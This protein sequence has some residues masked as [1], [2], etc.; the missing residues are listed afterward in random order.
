[1]SDKITVYG[2]KQGIWGADR[3]AEY[4]FSNKAAQNDYCSKHNYCD[5][6]TK[7]IGTAS[8]SPIFDTADECDAFI[9]S[10]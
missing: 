9:N 3:P 1:M 5:K 10:L 4:L 6:F 2:V 8:N 7:Q